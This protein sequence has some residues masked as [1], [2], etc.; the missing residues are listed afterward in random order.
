MVQS[1]EEDGKEDGDVLVSGTA[2]GG[3]KQLQARHC[4]HKGAN[5]DGRRG[6][7]ADMYNFGYFAALFVNIYQQTFSNMLAGN[8]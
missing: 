7:G 3:A 8:A 4:D 1:E 6:G 2:V 5:P